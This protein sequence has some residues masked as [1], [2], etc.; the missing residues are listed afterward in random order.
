MKRLLSLSSMSFRLTLFA[1]GIVFVY[2]TSQV[3]ASPSKLS[4][5]NPTGPI[6]GKT[7]TFRIDDLS[8]AE[9]DSK[10]DKL[11]IPK[12]SRDDIIEAERIRRE[13]GGKKAAGNIS[14]KFYG[15]P[16]TLA[17]PLGWGATVTWT[18]PGTVQANFF[19]DVTGRYLGWT[20][21]ITCP[22][23]TCTFITTRPKE[24]N[25]KLGG[26][27][28]WTSSWTTPVYVSHVCSP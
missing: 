20:A 26:I 22:G 13:H 1:L 16:W 11:G 27:W 8:L 12:K 6:D 7:A 9:I 18:A 5:Q 10:L 3:M 23:A 4:E 28:T 2:G 21:P 14:V 15:G 17:C 25:V 24:Y 19:N